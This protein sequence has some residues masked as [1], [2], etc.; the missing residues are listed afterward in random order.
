MCSTVTY[1]L[2]CFG[3]PT[4]AT[5][6]QNQTEQF[7][8]N[9]TN[10]GNT[11]VTWS[12]SPAGVGS[13]NSSGLYT[14]PFTISSQ[15]TV[16]VTAKSQADGTTQGSATITLYP[17]IVVSVSPATATLYANQTEQ[18]SASVT[19]TGNT[20]VTW[21]INP[22]GAGS[23]NSSGLYTAP[24]PVSAQQTV[25]VTALSQADGTT[26]GSATITLY[27]PVAVSLSPTTATLFPNQTEQFTANV[28]NTGNTAVTWSVSPAGTGSINSSGLYT[29]PATISTQQTVTVTATSQADST[30]VATAAV[31]LSP[32]VSVSVSPQTGMLTAGQT[33]AFSAT[34]TGA[35]STAVNWSISPAGVGSIDAAGV[36][37]APTTITSPQTVTVTAT[38]QSNPAA[39]AS[40]TVSLS[41]AC[42][43]AGFAFE[44][45][46]TID[47]TKVS[48]TDQTNFPFLFNTTDP[49]LA[50]TANGG[51][52]TSSSGYDIAFSTDPDGQNRLNYE[53]EEYNAATGQ[54]IAW[55]GIPALSHSQDTTIYM[56]YGNPAITS[57]QSNPAAVW[58]SNFVGVWHLPNGTTLATNDSTS[59][60]NNGVD[61]GATPTSGVVD[62]AASFNG[63]SYIN[64][65]NLG[66]FPAQGSIEFWMQPAS[67]SS[68]PNPFSTNYNGDNNGI[69]FE[70]DSRGDFSVAIG[71]APY[72]FNGYGY[73]TGTMQPGSWY[74][75][76]LTWNTA[77]STAT[78]YIDGAQIFTT[79]SNSLWPSSIPDLVIGSGYD[80]SR[81]WNGRID[82]ARISR[83]ARSAGWIAT[84][85]NNQ[86]SPATFYTLSGEI[87]G[88]GALPTGVK[89]FASQT[90]QFTVAGACDT[91]AV[92]AMTSGAPGTL[93]ASGLY[94]APPFIDAPQTVTITGTTLGASTQPYTAA[95]TLTPPVSVSVTPTSAVLSG[96]GTAQFAA[97]VANS[98]SSDVTWSVSPAG[99]GTVSASGFYSAP[100]TVAAQQTVIVTA[101][102]LEDWTKSASAT[103]TLMPPPPSLPVA[104]A[105]TPTSS[106]LDGGQSQQ[107]TATVINTSNSGVTWTI[108]PAGVGSIS[109]SGLYTAPS[110]VTAQQTVTITATSQA[111]TTKSATAMITLSPAACASNGYGY[112]RTIVVDHTKVPNTDQANFPVLFNTTDPL[113]AT[114]ANG[115]HVTSASGY[116]IVFSADPDGLTKLDFELEQYNPATGQVIAWIRVPNL[117]H[118]SDTVLYMFYGNPNVT[119]PQQNPTGAW[120]SNFLEVLHLD[121]SGGTTAFDSTANANNGTRVSVTSPTP[122]AAGFIGGAQSFNGTSDYIALPPAVTSGLKTFSV[123][124]WTQTTDQ[125]SN[126]TYWNEPE[127]LGDSTPGNSSGDF[128][129]ASNS[130]YLSMWSGLNSP[131]DNS[132]ISNNQISDNNWHLVDAVDDGTTTSLYLDGTFTGKTLAS[133]LDLDSYGWY[134]GAQ[135]YYSGGAAFFHEG[136]IDEFHF[137]NAARSVDWIATEYNNQS[138]PST[139]YALDPENAVEVTPSAVSLYAGQTQQFAATGMCSSSVTW[140]LSVDAPGNGYCESFNS[141]LRDEFLNGEIFYTLKEAQV[142]AERWRV[143]YNTE[144]PHSSLGYKPPAPAAWQAGN[145]T[146]H[147]KV[148]T[149]ARFHFS[150]PPT[151]AEELS[152]PLRYTNNLSGTK[153]RAGHPA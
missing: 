117:S 61:E 13:I 96:G 23:I 75:V 149:A 77:E 94:T 3:S 5:L 17:P 8:A 129:V 43:P 62:G 20:A 88:A 55:I 95:I 44:R 40:A 67:L 105:L 112:E 47:H 125:N 76:V 79:N 63:S 73:M 81:D 91:N 6:Y 38:S 68:Y 49:T 151:A 42:T 25:T 7:S 14:A 108:D 123:S 86:R 80:N 136:I 148:E 87:S 115:G 126:G 2:G 53:M 100:S 107:F 64:I 113:F 32:Q 72:T 98:N 45:A 127:F 122:T 140:S 9:V 135:H 46:I 11:A 133:G 89:L 106:T 60:G 58:D 12:I 144:R 114:T 143:Y 103:V 39:A 104:I 145:N 131:A 118:T 102:S 48:A 1:R 52:V 82:E 15:Q 138:S 101:T 18:F 141:R 111:D 90:V 150:T 19:N 28:T 16:T 120:D 119:T 121:E 99:A 93:T 59:N 84:E 10:T 24:S 110:T 36:Y 74:D 26:Q 142:L 71:D 130:G 85:Y 92:W 152:H 66:T 33:Q 30:A 31:T 70:E 57:Q 139:F 37:I 22:T 56:L 51:H 4:T 146:G 29:A 153:H 50:T 83:T 147:G 21:S 124:F 35:S 97:T 54:V 41:L 132:L 134:L 34:V 116:D 137:S 78:G 69:R 109:V 27:P 65:G 128:G